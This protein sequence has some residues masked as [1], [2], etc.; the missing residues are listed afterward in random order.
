MPRERLAL[1]AP[2]EIAFTLAG[3]AVPRRGPPMVLASEVPPYRGP[4]EARTMALRLASDGADIIAVGCA[5]DEEPEALSA[6]VEAALGAGRPVLAEAPTVGHVKA[7]LDAGAA[8]V[9][10]SAEMA[11]D[12]AHLLGSEHAVVVGS[13]S[14]SKL[15]RAEEEMLSLG[16][17]KIIID[18]SLQAPPLGFIESLVRVREAAARAKSPVQFT[19]ANVAEEVEAD[20][21]GVHGLLALAAAEA[22]ASV[23]YVVEDSYKSYR[24]TAEAREAVDVAL[25]A[26]TLRRPREVYSR[27]LVVKQPHPPPKP[28][29]VEAV[30]VG[31]VEPRMDKKGYI[32]IHV[33]HERGVIVAVYRFYRG[34]YVAVEGTHPTSIARELVRRVGLDPEHAAYLGYELSKAEIALRLGRSYI[35]DDPV[36]T[37]V[38]GVGECYE[39]GCGERAGE[40][41]TGGGALRGE[42][43][44]GSGCS[45]RQEGEGDSRA[46]WLEPRGCGEQ[47]LQAEG[48]A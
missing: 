43:G 20:T 10:V 5:F 13:D 38:W 36:I 3:V 42:R 31:Y 25:T 45:H 35:Q 7:A 19:A 8:G 2:A 32:T 9:I 12:V 33:D 28:P 1:R 21:H 37:P 18:P 16:V 6:R 22:R 26:W 47:P 41:N 48:K 17:S 40:G 34:G 11:A 24:S 4:K 23:Y 30:R 29:R 15:L 46:G 44:P 14:L 27:L 39:E